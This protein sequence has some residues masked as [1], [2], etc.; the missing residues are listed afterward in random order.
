MAVE[1]LSAFTEFFLYPCVRKEPQIL[2]DTT[3]LLNK[4]E[5]INYKFAP[6]PKGTLLVSWDV[7][8]MYP[9]INNE[10]GISACKKL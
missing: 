7:M 6:F 2:L 8:F 3:A 5:D 4:I 9:S 1:N 10:M